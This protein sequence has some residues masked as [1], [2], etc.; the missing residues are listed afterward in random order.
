MKRLVTGTLL[1][2]A[3]VPASFVFTA[4]ALA[5]T[6]TACSPV[7]QSRIIQNPADHPDAYADGYSEG[8]RSASKG[9]AYKPRTVGGEFARGFEDGYYKRSFTGQEYEVRDKVQHYTTQLCDTYYVPN[10]YRYWNRPYW[11]RPY[12]NRPYWNRPYWNRPRFRR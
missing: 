2:L 12:W 3:A 7:T 11:N 6:Y 5:S 10:R 8:R 4:Q 1:I 9:E